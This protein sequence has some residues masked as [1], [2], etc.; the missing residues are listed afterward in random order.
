[1]L[2]LCAGIAKSPQQR[3]RQSSLALPISIFRI[4]TR[5]TTSTRG[6]TRCQPSTS[7]DT[8]T[9]SSVP[10]RCIRGIGSPTFTGST[11]RR[12]RHVP[13]CIGNC[14]S[15]VDH[16]DPSHY[17][18]HALCSRCRRYRPCN[19]CHRRRDIRCPMRGSCST[20]N[21]R[22]RSRGCGW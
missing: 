18:N 22:L 2:D 14:L 3:L 12:G 21:P 5:S 11:L 19:R 13:V 15:R 8:S 17:R 1:M 9:R 6:R 10:T 20:G 7:I 4:T 16:S